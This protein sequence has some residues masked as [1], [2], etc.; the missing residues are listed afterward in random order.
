LLVVDDDLLLLL[1]YLL[2]LYDLNVFDPLLELLDSIIDL[3]ELHLK[4]REFLLM[5]SL[6]W[7]EITEENEGVHWPVA[8]RFSQKFHQTIE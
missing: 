5:R 3:S 1:L 6:S 2:L 4:I 7:R 8:E